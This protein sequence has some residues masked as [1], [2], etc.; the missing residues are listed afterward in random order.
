ML[1]YVPVYPL[2]SNVRISCLIPNPLPLKP[3]PTTTSLA[4][5]PTNTHT[6]RTGI[7]GSKRNQQIY[8][9]QRSSGVCMSIHQSQSNLLTQNSNA[10][11]QKTNFPQVSTCYQILI[12]LPRNSPTNAMSRYTTPIAIRTPIFRPVASSLYPITAA[13]KSV[14]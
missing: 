5:T 1:A 8:L 2:F 7:S 3:T 6:Y 13:A 9:S 11:N 14:W 10:S 4:P 12:L